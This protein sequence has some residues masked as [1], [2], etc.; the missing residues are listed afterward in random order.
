MKQLFNYLFSTNYNIMLIAIGSFILCAILF[1]YCELFQYP[2][3]LF[4]L[5]ILIIV[6]K[7]IILAW[8][9]NPIRNFK[10]K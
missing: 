1:N 7:E 6:V 8:I 5:Y 10:N 4:L 2:A 9:I 3:L